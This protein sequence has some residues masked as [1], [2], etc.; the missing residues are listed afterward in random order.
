MPLISTTVSLYVNSLFKDN[1][2]FYTRVPGN[3]KQTAVRIKA[4]LALRFK[5]YEPTREKPVVTSPADAAALVQ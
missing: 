5:L 1:P 4:A 2:D 3:E